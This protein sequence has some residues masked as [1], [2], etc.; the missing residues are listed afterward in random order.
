MPELNG[1]GENASLTFAATAAAVITS[2]FLPGACASVWWR[3]A[4][5]SK[6]CWGARRNKP[7]WAALRPGWRL[8]TGSGAPG[9]SCS[10][11]IGREHVRTP[12]T[13]AQTVCRLSLGQKK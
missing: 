11:E 1:E 5:A 2:G 12:V 8:D 7:D 4:N 9:W 13:H 3:R 6:T 10:S